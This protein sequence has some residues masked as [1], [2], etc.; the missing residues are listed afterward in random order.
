M[1]TSTIIR[2]IFITIMLVTVIA[3]YDIQ[4]SAKP[5]VLAQEAPKLD[6]TTHITSEVIT[7]G[8]IPVPTDIK[9]YIRYK[10]GADADKALKLLECENKS[11][12]PNAKNDNR[13]W[14]GV[15]VDRGYWQ[16]NDVYHPHVSDWCA[17]DVK[18]STDYAFRMWMNDG[19]S[20]E[21]WTCGRK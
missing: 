19:K 20:F 13:V 3:G 17:S 9:G 14:G 21:R 5:T 10:F 6:T 12:N 8:V 18:C 2:N 15:G 4:H 7:V 11:L 16:I 1:K